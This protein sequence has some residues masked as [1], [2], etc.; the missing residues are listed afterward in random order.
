MKEKTMQR[1]IF[2]I[3][4]LLLFAAVMIVACSSRDKG[5]AETAV[6]AAEEAVQTAKTETA[7]I[8]P[9]QV[10]AL[11]SALAS[12]K[13]K[14]AKG[15]Y[16]AAITEAEGLAGKAK[17]T[18][19]AAK[20]QKEDLP[21]TWTELSR[22]LHPMIAAAQRRMNLLN[23]ARK[24]P[25]YLTADQFAEAKA[26]FVAARKE[27]IKAQESYNAGNLED[28]VSTAKSVREKTVKAMEILGMPVPEGAKS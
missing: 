1:K 14:L 10:A 12:A 24:L 9:D 16:Q 17:E 19:A 13:D 4:V 28:A 7:K 23:T 11:E 21:R 8:V 22:G 6:K 15:D 3:A 2:S 27:W 26:T 5:P 20:T 18:V 25:D